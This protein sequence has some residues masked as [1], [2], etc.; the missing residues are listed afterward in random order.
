[1]SNHEMSKN[2]IGCQNGAFWA[3]CNPLFF[4]L[5]DEIVGALL[6]DILL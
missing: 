6:Q 1:M 2:Y 4:I 3:C 5:A